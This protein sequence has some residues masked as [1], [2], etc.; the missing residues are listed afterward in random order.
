[1]RRKGFFHGSFLLLIIIA[2]ISCSTESVKAVSPDQ[3]KEVALRYLR[4][5]AQGD[6]ETYMQLDLESRDWLERVKQ[7]IPDQPAFDR[8]QRM[9]NAMNAVNKEIREKFNFLVGPGDGGFNSPKWVVYR[10][11]GA[12]FKV[13]E[14]GP[15]QKTTNGGV[16]KVYVEAEG[17]GKN[18]IFVPVVYQN[19]KWGVDMRSVGIHGK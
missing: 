17:R 2:L 4:A 1:M 6:F 5:L 7:E 13:I 11:K 3:Y 19:G 12:A 10:L 14:V 8:Q 18:I 16:A 15:I 9:Q